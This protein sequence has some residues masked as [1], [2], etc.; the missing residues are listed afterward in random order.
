MKIMTIQPIQ[1]DLLAPL[2]NRFKVRRVSL[3]GSVVKGI[4]TDHSDVDVL[5]DYDFQ[6]VPDLFEMAELEQELERTLPFRR[7]VDMV[8]REDL[9]PML[10]ASIESTERVIYER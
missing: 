3:F 8:R 9:H 5:I 4:A 6:Y 7:P 2:A 1:H 10:R